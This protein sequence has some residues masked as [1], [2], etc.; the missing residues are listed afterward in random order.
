MEN[1]YINLKEQNNCY[2]WHW[3]EKKH[4]KDLISV[5]DLIGDLED[6]LS[7]Y[8]RLEEKYEDRERDIEYNFKRIS[9]ESMYR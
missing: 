3:L 5:D 4:N 1:I 7:D 2:I 8:E 9:P 6:L